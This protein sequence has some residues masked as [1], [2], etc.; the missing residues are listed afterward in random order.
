[1]ALQGKIIACGT[2]LTIY[3]MILRF[4]VGPATMAL[5]CVVLGLHGN[6]LRVAIIQVIIKTLVYNSSLWDLMLNFILQ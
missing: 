1:M 4:V 3:A 6:V 5:G 2:A